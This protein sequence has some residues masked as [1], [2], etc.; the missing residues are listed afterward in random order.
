MMRQDPEAGYIGA[1]PFLN[2][3][4]AFLKQIEQQPKDNIRIWMEDA[5]QVVRSLQDDCLDA[6]YILNPDPW[7]K[8][9]HHKRRIVRQD[10]LADYHRILKPGGVLILTTDVDEL[11]EWM[12]TQVHL[13]GG[14]DWQ[15]K[16][17]KDWQSAPDG[18]IE[19]RYEQK[20]ADAGRRQS[21]LVYQAI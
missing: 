13:H 6:I 2:G 18:W 4:S 17:A 19:T 7:P 12:A 20:G 15:A 10:T 5:L 16:S 8:A 14:F 1:E 3:M 11:A 21:Y 9:R